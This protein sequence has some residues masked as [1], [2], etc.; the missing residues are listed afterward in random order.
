MGQSHLDSDAQQGMSPEFLER[1]KQRAEAIRQAE[2]SQIASGA[3]DERPLAEWRHKTIH[4]HELPE[5]EQG[6]LRV[7][8]GGGIIGVDM[9]YCTFRGD[10]LRCAN[11]L[12]EAAVGLRDGPG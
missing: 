8:T 1:L 6:I 12:E 10:R 3:T 4:I 9:N 7:S 2:L 5:D 11:L